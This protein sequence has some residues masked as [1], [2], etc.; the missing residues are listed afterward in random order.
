VD[1]RIKNIWKEGIILEV[2]DTTVVVGCKNHEE[3]KIT[4]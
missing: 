4:F 2:T 3:K 1:F